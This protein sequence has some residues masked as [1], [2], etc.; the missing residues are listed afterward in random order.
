MHTGWYRIGDVVWIG[1][2]GKGRIV[3]RQGRDTTQ[4]RDT[5]Q[6]KWHLDGLRERAGLR[7][8]GLEGGTGLGMERIQ[9]KRRTSALGRAS[10]TRMNASYGPSMENIAQHS[11]YV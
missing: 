11:Q 8:T 1:R 10:R 2:G 7:R 3:M 9:N 4:G 5:A 6:G